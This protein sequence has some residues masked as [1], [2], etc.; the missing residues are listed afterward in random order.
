MLTHTRFI[1]IITL[2]AIATLVGCSSAPKQAYN[3]NEYQP[4]VYSYLSN[5]GTSIDE[6]IEKLEK[7]RQTAQEDGQALPPGFQAHL[8]MLYGQKGD[9]EKMKTLFLNE[10]TQF[11]ASAKYIDFLLSDK[12]KKISN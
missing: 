7:N 11:P 3:W 9:T 2:A 6:Q 4:S 8:G 1:R 12:S 10:K 5:N